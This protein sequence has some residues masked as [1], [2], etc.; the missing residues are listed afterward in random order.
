MKFGDNL[1]SIRKTRKVS[2]EELADK[3]GVSRQSVSKWET[4]ENYPSM[5]NIVC[6]CEIFKC[7]MNDLVHEDFEDIDFMDKEIKMSVVKLNKEEQKRMKVTS[8]ILYVLGKIGKICTRVGA[9]AIIVAMVIS[10]F[11]LSQIDFKD[12][13][14]VANGQMVKVVETE[15]GIKLTTT[16]NDHVV[17]AELE[18]EKVE[19]FKKVYNNL[20]KPG[21]I[22]TLDLAFGVL[23]AFLIVLGIVFG[24]FEK[25]FKNVNEGDTPFT[26]ENVNHIKKMSY[27]MI[28]CIILSGIGTGIVDSLFSGT[29]DLDFNAFS[30]VQILFVYAL[31]LIFEYGYRIQKDSNGKIY[32]DE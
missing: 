21:F 11:A 6:L 4:G 20:T 22:V 24:H 1:K 28:A 29:I 17:V 12:N 5:Q 18:N 2:Q 25:L 7:K 23:V 16:E 9:V 13:Q 32:G 26:L 19:D 8:K 15:N 10:T 14:I 30:I 27:L 3:L 31:S